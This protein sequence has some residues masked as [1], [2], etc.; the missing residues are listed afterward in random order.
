MVDQSDDPSHHERTLLPRSYISLLF[1]LSAKSC[2]LCCHVCSGFAS[3]YILCTLNLLWTSA[4]IFFLLGKMIEMV[5]LQTSFCQAGP[6]IGGP[7]K[8]GAGK[9]KS[10][11][12]V[13]ASDT[14]TR[15]IHISCERC[16]C[17]LTV[18]RILVEWTGL[19]TPKHEKQIG[20]WEREIIFLSND[21]LNTFYLRLYGVRHMV[22]D[23]SDS[24][25]GN[26]LPPHRLLLSINNKGS[27]ICTIPQTG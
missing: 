15:P 19:T 13:R 14:H 25:K 18:P 26:Q 20:Y 2:Q 9:K 4:N 22:K 8:G 17:I 21:P 16:Q 10:S 24:E 11:C 23:H 6:E 12:I 1:L 3:C 5:R 27:F 7:L